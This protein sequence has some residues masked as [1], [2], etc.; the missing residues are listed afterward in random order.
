MCPLKSDTMHTYLETILPGVVVRME[1]SRGQ[2]EK[3]YCGLCK[4]K[5]AESNGPSQLN[6]LRNLGGN[7]RIEILGYGKDE[8]REC[9]DANLKDN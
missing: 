5:K 4:K 2:V 1:G 6:E 7:L 3:G 9:K 8:V